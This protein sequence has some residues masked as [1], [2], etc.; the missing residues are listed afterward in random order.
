[1]KKISASKHSQLSSLLMFLATKVYIQD[2]ASKYSVR[3][4]MSSSGGDF[5]VKLSKRKKA[6]QKHIGQA[7]LSVTSNNLADS[8][9]NA[10]L[11][12]ALASKIIVFRPDT[13]LNPTITQDSRSPLLLA[14]IKKQSEVRFRRI[15][16]SKA[17]CEGLAHL[18]QPVARLE[19]PYLSPFSITYRLFTT[20]VSVIFGSFLFRSPLL[21]WSVMIPTS[22]C[23]WNRST[24]RL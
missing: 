21:C 18:P 8:S 7:G 4:Y 1:M 12:R 23:F 2:T 9:T 13:W 14:N 10:M 16:V 6:T 3:K 20:S 22:Y 5:S 11:T 15:A 24:F 17:I 19:T